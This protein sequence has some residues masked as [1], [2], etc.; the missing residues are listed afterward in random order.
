M[1][2]KNTGKAVAGAEVFASYEITVPAGDSFTTDHRWV[3]T[4]ADG[5]FAIP[6]HIKVVLGPP[7]SWTEPY[8]GFQVVHREYGIFDF[9]YSGRSAEDFP[10]WRELVFEIEPDL[11]RQLFEDRRNWA[12]LCSGLSD[13]ACDRMCMVVYDSLEA[14]E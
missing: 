9:G 12:G 8:P 5:S 2:E 4:G 10:G 1:V 11:S 13:D 7:R 14:C 3:T 6:A